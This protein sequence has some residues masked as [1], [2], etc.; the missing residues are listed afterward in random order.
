MDNAQKAIMIGVGLFITII[1]ISAV[2]LI[3]NLGTNMVENAG[4][5][6]AG[7]SSQLQAQLVSKYDRK[8]L[9]GAEVV[10]AWAS[11]ADSDSVGIACYNGSTWYYAGKYYLRSTYL[12]DP[13]GSAL[14]TTTTYNDSLIHT[15]SG[16]TST[17]TKTDSMSP[18]VV[19]TNTY[20]SYLVRHQTSGNVIGVVF[21]KA[22]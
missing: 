8:K 7:L 10:T 14:S 11:Y 17:F 6:V 12:R 16:L 3:T 9:S 21:I 20:N 4:N 13:N 22:N 19:N 5:E 1:I 2:L 15:G 18:F